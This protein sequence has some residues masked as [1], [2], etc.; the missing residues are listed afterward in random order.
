MKDVLSDL[1]FAALCRAYLHATEAD[2]RRVNEMM[3]PEQLEHFIICVGL[4]RI[5]DDP[6]YHDKIMHAAMAQFIEDLKGE[7]A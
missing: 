1:K 7:Q 2:R 6:E 4:I 5:M 3:T